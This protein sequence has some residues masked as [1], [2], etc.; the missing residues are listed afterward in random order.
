MT[1]NSKTPLHVAAWKG[2][3]EVVSH[4]LSSGGDVNAQVTR[5]E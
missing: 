2:Q 5:Q 1:L 3:L 4:L